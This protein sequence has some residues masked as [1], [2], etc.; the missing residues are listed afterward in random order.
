MKREILNTTLNMS[1]LENLLIDITQLLTNKSI[2]V[3]PFSSESL[4]QYSSLLPTQKDLITQQ[5]KNYYSLLQQI[6]KLN[7][8]NPNSISIQEEISHVKL[9]LKHFNLKCINDDYSFIQKGDLIEIYSLDM[10][11]LYRNIEFFRQCSYDLLTLV[12]FEWPVLYERSKLITNNIVT[13]ARQIMTTAHKAEPYLIPVHTLKE[14]Y[15]DAKNIFSVNLKSMVPLIDIT[16]NERKGGLHSIQ[17]TL[18]LDK[19][20]N[21]QLFHI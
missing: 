12:T 14:R 15:V 10:I 17:S 3:R 13:R 4:K 11:Q 18:I 7:S 21:T 6:T 1:L 9:A 2:V 8:E 16:T 19:D 5:L 20:D